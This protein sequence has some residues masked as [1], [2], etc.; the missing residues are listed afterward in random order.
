MSHDV[1]VSRTPRIEGKNRMKKMSIIVI[2]LLAVS[3]L[4]SSAFACGGKT[5][6]TAQKKACT[7]TAAATGSAGGSDST[8]VAAV[9]PYPLTTCIIS[10]EKLGGMGDPVVK[11]YNGRQVKFCCNGCVATF[12]KDLAG[13]FK[14]IDDAA[15]AQAAAAKATPAPAPTEAPAPAAPAPAAPTE[16]TK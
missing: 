9:V 7:M 10:G 12:E 14:K 15:A 1:I 2:V 5:C 6:G 4:A 3:L 11:V 8:A 13:N 16:P